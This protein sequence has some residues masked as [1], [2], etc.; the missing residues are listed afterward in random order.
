MSGHTVAS[1]IR[2]RGI[3]LVHHFTP[4]RF[5]PNV[6]RRNGLWC[7]RQLREWDDDFD[8]DR[9]KWGSWEK[10]DEFASYISCGVNSPMGMMKRSNK[11]VILALEPEVATWEGDIFIGKW[12]SHGDIELETCHDWTG[13]EYFDKMFLHEHRYRA[14]HPG[15]FLVPEHIALRF[16]Q[17]FIFYCDED[18]EEARRLVTG[19]DRPDDVPRLNVLV[20]PVPFGIR[21]L[22]E[23]E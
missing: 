13:V 7:A 11:P 6:I 15:E 10:G 21:V 2:R 19:I 5:L 17:K 9:Q 20:D 3:K 14:I 16:V 1:S 23:E 22:E 18:L 12:S 8:D 4:L